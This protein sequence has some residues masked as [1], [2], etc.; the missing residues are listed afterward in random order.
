[1][2][3]TWLE[4]VRPLRALRTIVV[5]SAWNA[6][7]RDWGTLAAGDET[8]VLRCAGPERFCALME[9]HPSCPL[10]EQADLAI[11]D[12]S[13]VMPSFW[14]RLHTAHPGLAVRFARDELT[15]EGHHRP[16]V[17]ASSDSPVPGEVE[18]VP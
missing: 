3:V 10:L 15:A 16:R 4:R 6:R 11:Y 5:V 7:R 9:G 13:A 17:I 8:R 2:T 12:V 1:M 14:T 18:P